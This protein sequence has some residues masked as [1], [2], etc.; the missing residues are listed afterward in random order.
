MKEIRGFEPDVFPSEG[1]DDSLTL[2]QAVHNLQ[3]QLSIVYR[4]L[5][6]SIEAHRTPENRYIDHL[7]SISF[8]P[9]TNDA[10]K[11]NV[12]GAKYAIQRL[13]KILSDLEHGER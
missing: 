2:V 7:R 3:G 12:L 9:S 11:H 5:A 10:E 6:D 1:G 8:L 13:V 4:V